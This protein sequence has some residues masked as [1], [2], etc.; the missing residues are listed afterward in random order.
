MISIALSLLP[1]VFVMVGTTFLIKVFARSLALSKALM[2]SA[3]SL[4]PM[5]VLLVAYYSLKH[6]VALSGSMD[7]IAT[8]IAMVVLGVTITRWLQ[9][10]GIVKGRWL[11][12]GGKV[13]LSWVAIS[14]FLGGAY[15]LID[16]FRS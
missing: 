3:G 7:S 5:I 2:V 15:L 4:I 14:W 8:I 6:F 12:V 9:R 13:V 1:F 16:H 11:G 10:Y